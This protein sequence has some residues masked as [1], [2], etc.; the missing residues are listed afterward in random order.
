MTMAF[1]GSKLPSKVE[2]PGDAFKTDL[3]HECGYVS[4][5]KMAASV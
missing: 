4:T 5:Q 2:E 1:T 3:V